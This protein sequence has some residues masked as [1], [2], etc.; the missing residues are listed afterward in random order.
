MKKQ[1]CVEKKK[2]GTGCDGGGGITLKCKN[3][4]GCF[5]VNCQYLLKRALEIHAVLC[6]QF[7]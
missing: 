4:V 3:Y 7:Y 6:Q 5:S 1:V 2:D